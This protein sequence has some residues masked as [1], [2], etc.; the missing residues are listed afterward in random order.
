[1][2]V[3]HH[4]EFEFDAVQPAGFIDLVKSHLR[5]VFHRNTVGCRSAGQWSRGTDIDFGIPGSI[6]TVFFL[7]GCKTCN[8]HQCGEHNRKQLRPMFH[9]LLPLISF[10]FY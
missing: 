4:Y 8:H 3:I 10:D 9:F 6:I 1:M 7:T 5:R 2:L